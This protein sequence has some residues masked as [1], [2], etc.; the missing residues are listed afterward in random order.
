[1]GA[2]RIPFLFSLAAA[3][4]AAELRVLHLEPTVLFPH[5][6]PLRQIARLALFSES[7]QPLRC[8]VS[9]LLK[10]AAPVEAGVLE[11]SPGYSVHEILVPDVQVRTPLELRVTHSAE[12]RLLASHRQ[13]WMPQ[14]KWKIFIV[15]SSHEDLGYEDYIFNKQRDIA[16]YIDLARAISGPRD[17]PPDSEEAPSGRYHYTLESLLFQRNYIEERSEA[18]WREIVER[19]IKPGRMSLMGAPHGIHSHWMDYEELVRATYPGR[20]EVRDRFGLDLKTFMI[21]DNP[22][23]SWSGCQAVA[24]AGFRYVARWG[25]GWRT[26]SNNDYQ[27]TKLPAIFWWQA[28]DGKNR[29]LFAWRSHYGLSLWYGQASGGY[30]AFIE[31]GAHNL[32]SVL[33]KVESG[34]LLGPYPYDALVNPEYADHE[35]PYYPRR[36]LA[37][38]ARRYRYPEI[39]IAD[40]TEFFQYI[41]TKYA[42]QL[43]VLSGDLNN[44][45]A[46]YAAIDPDSHGIKRRAA[47]LLPL[48]EALGAIAGRLDPSFLPPAR[49]IDRTFT[50]LFDYDEHSWPTLPQP[51]D[52][53]LFNAQ[54]V[55]IHEAQRA[56]EGARKALELS[57]GALARHIA[58]P[59]GP[60]VVVF[61]PLAHPRTDV[62]EVDASIAGLVDSVTGRPA[63][64][65]QLPG[66]RT[67]FIASNVP[68]FGYKTYRVV[69]DST[70]PPA[71]LE[72]REDAVS[73]QYYEIRLDRR[74]GAIESIFDKQL[75]RE[76]VDPSAAVRFNQFIYYETKARESPEGTLHSPPE[77]KALARHV[78]P[79]RADLTAVIEDPVT[80][81]RI[82]QTVILYDGL[83]RIDI[84][85]R[86]EDV[87][88]L[89]PKEYSDRYRGNIY[90]AFPLAVEN[91]E[92][93]VEYPAGVV[94][95]YTDQLRW[96]SH[97]YLVANWWVDVSNQRYGV[98]MAPWNAVTVNFGEIRY[99]RFSI[100]YRP[101]SPHLY[102]YVLSNRMG[103]LLWLNPDEV[104]ATVRYSFTSHAGDWNSGAV[105][106][107]G[108]S[109]A[110]PLEARL[111]AGGQKGPLPADQFSFL[112]ISAPNVRLLTLKQS[113][114]P[115]RGWVV[116]LVE[117]E[118]KPTDVTLELPGFPLAKAFESDL[119]ENDRR[120]LEVQGRTIRLRIGPF[121]YSTIR[122]VGPSQAPAQVRDLRGNAISD[123]AIRLTWTGASGL[124]YNIYRS[125]DLQAPPT[126]YTLV[127][128]SD[129]AE[130]LDRGLELDT[131]YRYFVAAV[132][133]DNLQG[134]VSAP[135]VVRTLR[136]NRTPPAPVE[137]LGVVRR[138]PDR[139]ILYWRKSPEPDVARYFIHRAESAEFQATEATLV[140]VQPPTDRFLQI[141]ADPNLQPGKTY[142]YRV[143][144]EDWA[145]NRQR[146]SPLASA[147][148]PAR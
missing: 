98:T 108:W 36:A 48:A 64:V 99:N 91:F 30:G 97:D 138:A 87:R 61:N 24:E 63:P 107:F 132:T 32:D 78:G 70:R 80:G 112:S 72:A 144:A 27:R 38:W 39:R 6:R 40:P 74:S 65:E 105:T 17:P 95:P 109:V 46:D 93:R 71:A 140:A 51:S 57:Y 60:A 52:H 42:A 37:E 50:R 119:V 83:K 62:V 26:G 113:E 12:G 130:Y 131:A 4:C 25:Q 137:E 49:L 55:K 34:E 41:E 18:A 43:P 9:V 121:A 142:Y 67:L 53:Q 92:A 111:C 79:V 13:D 148:T 135:V 1:M 5:G 139:L 90:Y 19:D 101:T 143:F 35:V 128:R 122:F 141:Y 66:G 120:V 146:E 88:K 89:F 10:D 85:N 81:A 116:R 106:R 129:K 94:R 115:G 133:A 23:L 75:K 47:R 127:G 147:T 2:G 31:A 96:G 29:V 77:A 76:L 14:R 102:S 54:W 136:E 3:F 44:F 82:T 69:A 84:V 114:Q 118:G 123:S 59:S 20:R 110:S 28:P 56:L 21:V 58:T 134:P 73:N 22:S 45:S 33:K 104:G 125:K 15:K 103:D 16:F 11:V 117:T 100:D 8:R 68:S 86:L 126:A 145:G 124:Y 7:T